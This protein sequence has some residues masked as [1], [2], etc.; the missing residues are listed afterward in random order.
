[1]EAMHNFDV[2]TYRNMKCDKMVF[3]SNVIIQSYNWT[4]VIAKVV[5]TSYFSSF[6]AV[7]YFFSLSSKSLAWQELLTASGASQLLDAPREVIGISF[8]SE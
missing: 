1:M 7:G 4:L 8:D 3:P 2:A 5:V 6:C